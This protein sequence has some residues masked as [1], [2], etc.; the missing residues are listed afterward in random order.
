M[1]LWQALY[2]TLFG[3]QEKKLM[4]KCK[5]RDSMG[6]GCEGEIKLR[7]SMTA[8]H[9]DKESG[10]PNP[11]APFMCCQIHYETYEDYWTEMWEE[12]YKGRL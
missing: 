7:D 3:L 11:N 4:D 8:Y 12:Y 9:W 5:Y 1:L 2:Y 6:G 10:D